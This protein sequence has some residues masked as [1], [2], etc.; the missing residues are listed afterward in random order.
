MCMN[1]SIMSPEFMSGAHRNHK[2]TK[3]SAPPKPPAAVT[4]RCAHQQ[5][6]IRKL[7]TPPQR[8]QPAALI[9]VCTLYTA[10]DDH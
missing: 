1:K 6:H 8:D 5:V 9:L 4:A 7:R 10:S 3:F 2:L